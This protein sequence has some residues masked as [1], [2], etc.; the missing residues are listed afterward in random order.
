MKKFL[1]FFIILIATS[2]FIYSD[3]YI[4]REV[5][6]ESYYEDGLMHPAVD[7]VIETWI[8]NK[9]MAYISNSR[10][11]IV[12]LNKNLMFFINKNEKTYVEI[13]LPFELAKVVTK[14]IAPDLQYSTFS[15]TVK[16][17]KESKTIARWKCRCYNINGSRPYGREIKAWVHPTPP[18]DVDTYNKMNI[19]VLKLHNYDSNFIKEMQKIRGIEIRLDE[20]VYF[21]GSIRK[22]TDKILEISKK[23]PKT[24]SYSVPAGYKKKDKLSHQDLEQ[25]NLILFLLY[26]VKI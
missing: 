5:H 8:G 20:T 15:G 23:T 16:A 2:S 11:I 14:Q 24:I 12:D 4:K 6:T 19:N 17:T 22:R 18:F 7:R 21:R 13:P 25:D 10:I 3:V 9:K 1:L 26:P